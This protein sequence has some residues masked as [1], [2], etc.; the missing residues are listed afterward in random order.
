MLVWE[1]I[2]ETGMNVIDDQHQYLVKLINDLNDQV[3]TQLEFDNYD[4]IMEI[5]TELRQ[6][7]QEHFNHEEQLMKNH[8][9]SLKDEELARFWSYFKNHRAQHSAFVA[10][11]QQLFD[12]DVDERQAEISIELINFL[13]EW[14]KNHIL[15]IDMQLPGYL[16]A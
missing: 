1:K 16:K 14:L 12:K 11:V 15:K 8:M 7:A 10:K 2:Y 6:Y 13:V 5:L 4:K 9:E 3:V